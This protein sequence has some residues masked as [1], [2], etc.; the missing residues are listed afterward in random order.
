MTEDARLRALPLA[1]WLRLLAFDAELRRPPRPLIAAL[2]AGVDA[3]EVGGSA[4]SDPSW[5]T[6]ISANRPSHTT[7]SSVM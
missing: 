2:W 7:G 6:G 5:R 4:N 1:D 3:L